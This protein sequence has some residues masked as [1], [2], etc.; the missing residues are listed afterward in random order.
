MQHA[1]NP[2]DWYP[3]CDE[4]FEKAKAE[5]KLV[6]VS[7]GY[8]ACHWCHVMEHECFED[9]EV[10]KMMNENFVCI[11]V[12]REERP[13]VD[14]LYMDAV[15]LMS[16]R[17]GWPLNCFTLPD[18][19]PVYG[20]TY[21]PKDHW[22]NVLQSLADLYRNEP[23]KVNDFANQMEQGLK[24]VAMLPDYKEEQTQYDIK[25]VDSLIAA[26][27][28]G[29]DVVW[30]GYG[31]AP[32]FPMPNVYEFLLHYAY[33]LNNSGRANEAKQ[34]RDYVFLTLD[35]MAMG[36]IYDVLEGGFARYSTDTFWKAPHFEKML[37]DNG[38]LMSLYA[39]AYRY[40]PKPQYKEV[41]YGIY[42][43]VTRKLLSPEGGF[44]CALDAD[45]EGMEGKYYTWT[46]E[47]LSNL[48]GDDF[49][50]F[51][52]Y[53]S[54]KDDDAWEHGRYILFRKEADDVF[55]KKQKITLEELESKKQQWVKM[56]SPYRQLRVQPGLDDKVLASWNGLML[57]GL[58]EAYK[59]FGDVAFMDVI[60]RNANFICDK[61][62]D[63][64]GA[65]WRSY[66]NGKASIP[67]FLDDYAFVADGFFEL[68]QVSFDEKWLR[69]SEALVVHALRHFYDEG[70]N[71]FYYTPDSQKAII[72]RKAET[73][74]NVIPASNSA[75]AKLLFRLGH[76]LGNQAYTKMA[77]GML[78]S[79]KNSLQQYP[80]GYTNW[81]IL[82]L[83]VCSPFY[84]V[85]ITGNEANS[86]RDEMNRKYLPNKIMVG[87]NGQSKL[88]LLKGKF[89]GDKTLIYVCENKTCYA[90]VEKVEEA[91]R[92]IEHL[93]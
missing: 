90:P 45:S 23:A 77:N 6:L 32:K 25:F 93:K 34:A 75:M 22:L 13:D 26:M 29:F 79:M 20:G 3:W 65:L 38:Q 78:D 35:K 33:I 67:A 81:G 36:G 40:S 28:Q 7:I 91:I 43:F 59:A 69:V 5:H 88:E 63:K 72:T 15:H 49:T 16:G 19:R 21:F 66:K 8:S 27:Q 53:Y 68:Y 73:A 61:L 84:E 30:G 74:D 76:C 39:N 44:Y 11:K 70:K 71:M 86:F 46:K 41:V 51:A 62:M 37:Y 85:A 18:G 50:L 2:V 92:A 17:G 64:E 83:Q 80:Y 48:I 87:S 89:A 10:A 52:E 56:L 47:E 24:N 55:C 1:N 42:S 14:Q 31:N 58:I 57:I 4:A 9:A 82:A 60:I 12:D 54:I